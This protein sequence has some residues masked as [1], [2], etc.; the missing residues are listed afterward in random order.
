MNYQKKYLK[1]KEKY[2]SIKNQI[3]GMFN[4]CVFSHKERLTNIK[5]ITFHPNLPFLVLGTNDF[6]QLWNC[7]DPENPRPGLIVQ[8]IKPGSINLIAFH[9]NFPLLMSLSYD[10]GEYILQ[11]WNCLDIENII[12]INIPNLTDKWDDIRYVAFHPILPLLAIGSINNTVKLWEWYDLQ[13]FTLKLTL[14]EHTGR[15]DSFAFHPKAPFLATGSSDGLVKLWDCSEPEN[16]F[17]KDLP[18]Q[19][20]PIITVAFHP[21]LSILAIGCVNNT[22]KLWD[23]EKDPRN[24]ILINNLETSNYQKLAFHPKL[25]ILAMCSRVDSTIKLWNFPN[26][27]NPCITD[28]VGHDEDYDISSVAFHPT[29]PLLASLSINGEIKLWK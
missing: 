1:Y 24:P 19:T 21:T 27:E 3:G 28:L 12:Y 26:L 20:R 18:K 2:L 7:S 14:T 4:T 9:Q 10:K 6:I 25:S 8:L 17:I 15:V 22:V 23:C 5:S 13:N 16:P 11:L 29:L